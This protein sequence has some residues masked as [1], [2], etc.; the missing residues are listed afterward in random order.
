MAGP[1]KGSCPAL[2][3]ILS[4]LFILSISS[5]RLVAVLTLLSVGA[6]SRARETLHSLADAPE[7]LADWQLFE[8]RGNRLALTRGTMPYDLS[9]PLFSDYAH[10]WRA[11]SVPQGTAIQHADDGFI[12]PIGT[13]ISKTFYYPSPKN[14]SVGSDSPAVLKAPEQHSIGNVLG[15]D[16]IRLIETRLLVNSASG[17]LALPYV[18]NDAQTEATLALAGE[19][20]PLEI[21][22][23]AGRTPFTYAVP[24]ANQC[25]SCHGSGTESVRIEPIG[26]KPRHLDKAF[27]YPRGS[28]NQL[29]HW[30]KAGLLRGAVSSDAM[31]STARWN[32]EAASL[33]ARVRAYLDVNCGHC[34]SAN[35]GANTSGL[36]LDA[37]ERDPLRLGVCKIPVATGRGSGTASFDIVPGKPDESI[38]LY[39]MRSTEPDVAMPEL[40]RALLHEEGI[41]LVRR[42][43]DSLSGDCL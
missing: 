35:G 8:R 6:H 11:I 25:A 26:V 13:I 33:E 38:L 20:I 1:S 28:E 4:I 43:I 19:L 42:W 10:K 17:W 15:L 5:L 9:T 3:R 23:D 24:D 37:S 29:A 16:G 41:A 21:V 2:S 32:D 12:F 36:F 30:R 39:R 18:W 27:P 7:S 34:H 22:V 40:G 31:T 14:S